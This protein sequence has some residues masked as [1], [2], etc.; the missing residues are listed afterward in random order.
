MLPDA[1]GGCRDCRRE[2]AAEAAGRVGLLGLSIVGLGYSRVRLLGLWHVGFRGCRWLSGGAAGATG[3]V[4][5][6]GLAV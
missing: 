5:F 3:R 4:G 2:R 1:A 6:L